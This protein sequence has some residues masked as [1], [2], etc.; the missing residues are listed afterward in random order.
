MESQFSQYWTVFDYLPSVV[1]MTLNMWYVT[2]VN[3]AIMFNRKLCL[4]KEY[5]SIHFVNFYEAV[6][7]LGTRWVEN[8]RIW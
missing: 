7:C 5:I 2:A 4:Y 6:L 8:E 3:I 1:Y